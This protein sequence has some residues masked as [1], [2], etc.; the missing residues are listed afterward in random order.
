M[1]SEYLLAVIIGTIEG[2]TEFLPIS[3]TGHMIVAGELL[4]F[5][6]PRAETFMIFIQLGAILAIVWLYWERFQGL[7]L[8]LKK[9]S[10]DTN[11]TSFQGWRGITS[12]G[13]ASLPVLIA[14]F[15]LHSTIKTHL[16]SNTTV[17]IAL[18]LGGIVMIAVE[19][20]KLTARVT[21]LDSL[22]YK[23]AFL[24]GC[25][26]CFALWP[27]MSRSGSTIVGG[28]L[29]GLER[30]VA[31]EFSFLVAVPVMCAAVAYDLLK[32]MDVL[33]LSDIPFF[34]VGFVV[35]FVVAILAVKGFMELL[36]SWTLESFGIYRILVGG[37]ILGLITSGYLRA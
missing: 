7:L 30:R 34:G 18:L 2:I 28:M 9:R 31:A 8:G 36:K 33:E 27:G 29:L 17:A 13:V 20:F 15:L 4:G 11:S 3:S 21:S 26:Q 14:G 25:T 6:G 16:F 32:S 10:D 19:R 24:V 12:L 5:T 37:L 1:V 23:D 22:S 35:S